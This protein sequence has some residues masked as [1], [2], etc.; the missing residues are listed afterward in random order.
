MLSELPPSTNTFLKRTE[1]IIG[2]RTKGHRPGSTTVAQASAL[3][4]VTGFSDQAGSLMSAIL[5]STL[6]IDAMVS[7]RSFFVALRLHPDL[8]AKHGGSDMLRRF[9]IGVSRI[10]IVVILVVFMVG[11]WL[12]LALIIS[13][14]PFICTGPNVFSEHVALAE[15][16]ALAGMA[17]AVSLEDFVTPHRLHA[18]GFLRH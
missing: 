10:F 7:L 11:S 9:A 14:W 17:W 13:A 8:A 2:L 3:L 15:S 12:A 1:P 6:E 5:P 4:N 16:V 18:S